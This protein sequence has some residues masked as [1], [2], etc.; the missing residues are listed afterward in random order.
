MMGMLT[1]M[2]INIV[3]VN[4]YQAEIGRVSCFL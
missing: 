4:N 3:D 2:V 1:T